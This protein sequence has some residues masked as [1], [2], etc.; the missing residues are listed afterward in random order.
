MA[1]K[2][3]LTLV[4][5]LFLVNLVYADLMPPFVQLHP[6]LGGGNLAGQIA[7]SFLGNLVLNF[8]IFGAIFCLFL[9]N[10]LQENKVK[11]FFVSLLAVTVLGFLSDFVFVAGLYSKIQILYLCGI[12]VTSVLIAL[13]DFVFLKKYLKVSRKEAAVP[14][15]LMA[16]ITNPIMLLF[17]SVVL[18]SLVLF[19]YLIF[20]YAFGFAG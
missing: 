16:I 19:V 4:F 3:L 14:A 12:F 6:A 10:K 13:L 7:I 9:R 17:W 1:F 5:F 2:K 20:L 15:I 18:G 8:F 11:K